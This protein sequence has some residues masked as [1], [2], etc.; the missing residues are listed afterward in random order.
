MQGVMKLSTL[1]VV[2]GIALVACGKSHP[3]NATI[4]TG[5]ASGGQ[6]ACTTAGATRDCHVVIGQTNGFAQC[7][8]GKQ[9]CDGTIWGACQA[10]GTKGASFGTTLI[11]NIPQEG[12][13]GKP[14]TTV[15]GAIR[16]LD[17]PTP[18]SQNASL[19]TADPCDPYCWGWDDSGLGEPAA[20]PI[21]GDYNLLPGSAK[22][23]QNNC[24][25][26]VDMG[27]TH[28]NDCQYDT[29]CPK[30]GKQCVEF[31]S[32]NSGR[33]G[34]PSGDNWGAVGGNSTGNCAAG[35]DF[36]AAPAC[37]DTL[38]NSHVAIC[39]RGGVDDTTDKILIGVGG[40]G[41][42]GNYSFNASVGCTVDLSMIAGGLRANMCADIEMVNGKFNN[43]V[44][45][46]VD[47]SSLGATPAAR[48]T[49]LAGDHAIRLNGGGGG[50][51]GAFGA[52]SRTDNKVT[53]CDSDNNWSYQHHSPCLLDAF[54]P[55]FAP[56]A[57][58][59]GN[60]NVTPCTVGATQA[61]AVKCQYDTCCTAA[62]VCG[63]WTTV[64]TIGGGMCDPTMTTAT[65]PAIAGNGTSVGN[66]A[67]N[68]DFT[69]SLGCNNGGGQR[70][71]RHF[72][73]CNR[74]AV[75]SPLLAAGTKMY[76]SFG[77]DGAPTGYPF[78]ADG[79]CT[80]DM[81]IISI[82]SQTCGDLN[83]VQGQWN[84]SPSG[85]DCSG[86]GSTPKDRA[87]FFNGTD[88]PVRVNAHPDS[89]GDGDN[90]IPECDGANNFSFRKVNLKCATGA[91][92]PPVPPATLTYTGVCQSGYHVLWKWMSYQLNGPPGDGDV[93]VVA[94]TQIFDP[95]TQALK[96]PSPNHN[97]A[98]PPTGPYN[99]TWCDYTHNAGPKC[100]INL[101]LPP[102]ASAAK[103]AP[104]QYGEVLSLT[105]T[106]SDKNFFSNIG[107]AYDCVPY[108]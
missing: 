38:G 81:S 14:R 29:C 95:V 86:I 44:S 34:T 23:N 41:G 106:Y 18:S 31:G 28:E 59:P 37:D 57:T 93:N 19:C 12:V 87:D 103:L 108:E 27:H 63:D 30:D 42:T 70:P 66:C 83:A 26:H 48:L 80:L 46:A 100:P 54:L 13:H 5:P 94:T 7:M 24:N 82:A 51:S 15:G 6:E 4:G 47:C 67:A 20:P 21:Q 78:H 56:A 76:V 11:S 84:G 1:F 102:P 73:V 60:V 79:Y 43:T 97:V 49:A 61:D 3:D 58:L 45:P 96:A 99:F 50:G 89:T 85:V 107:V 9:T 53:E 105:L 104:D 69:V 8:A 35:V 10:D 65:L 64:G 88:R 90:A 77:N 36:T 40:A 98:D 71:D 17:D 74:G 22:I 16:V 75:A 62:L 33:C 72:E 52:N 68:P 2:A 32:S 55:Y 91:A 39:N 25:V 92:A 101:G